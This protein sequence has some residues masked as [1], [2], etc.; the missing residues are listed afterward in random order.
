[1]ELTGVPVEKDADAPAVGGADEV[2]FAEE[3]VVSLI[4]RDSGEVE[5]GSRE[6]ETEEEEREIGYQWKKTTHFSLFLF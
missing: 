5:G 3:M 2:A 6:E 4:K 1:M